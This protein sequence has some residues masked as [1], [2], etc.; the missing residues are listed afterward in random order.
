MQFAPGLFKPTRCVLTGAGTNLE[1]EYLGTSKSEVKGRL[2]EVPSQ[3][4]QTLA[5][6]FNLFYSQTSEYDSQ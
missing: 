1:A 5:S 6:K 3:G 2:A 4:Y